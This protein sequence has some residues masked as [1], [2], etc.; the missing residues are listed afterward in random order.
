MT[1]SGS[2]HDEEV[3]GRVY[4]ARMMRRLWAYVRPH[5]G[6]ITL[7]L[8]LLVAVSAAQLAQP[9][10]IKMAIDGPIANGDARGLGWIVAAFAGLLVL[11]FSLRYLQIYAL[12]KTGQNVVHDL[13]VQVYGHLQT[14]SSNFFDRNPVGRLVTRVTTDVETLAEVFSS[15]VVTLLGDSLKLVGIVVLLFWMDARLAALTVTV[16]PL[17]GVVAFLFRI[18]IRDAFRMVRSRVARLNAYLAETLGGMTVVQLF[19]RERA[20]EKEFDEINRAHRDADLSS[21]VYDSIFSSIIELVGTLSLAMILWYG[22]GRVLLGA[23]TFGTLVAFLEYA[24]KF[25]GPIRELGGYYSV[26]QSAMASSER[27]FALMDT[28]PEIVAPASPKRLPASRPGVTGEVVFDDVRFA[29][30]GGPDVLRGLSFRAHPGEKVALVGSTGAGKTTVVR[31]LLRLYD[32]QEG[33][34]YLDGVNVRDLDP[35]ELRRR[36]GVVLQDHVLFSGTI[37]DNI[38]LGDAGI[39]R[40]RIERA[41]EAVRAHGFIGALPRGYDDD[42]RERGSNFSMGQRQLLSFARALAFDP[43]VLVLDEATASVDSRTEMEI[44]KA[45]RT[46]TGGRTSLVIAHRLSTI[47]ESD[48]ILVLHHGVV[49]EEGSHQQL[50]EM[51]GLYRMLH[52]LQFLEPVPFST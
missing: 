39:S 34:I 15:G 19:Q 35:R 7:S 30:P 27:I 17:L 51:D 50:L 31:L 13:R 20:N 52:R 48:R 1:G 11:E 42:V 4:D 2:H 26:M 45:L 43:P 21:V 46:L 23:I 22:G 9:Y 16:L 6:L 47:Q 18:R 8:L 33:A 3:L 5:H 28:A 25:F 29:Y 36:V 49:R 10:L 14:L 24:Q 37:A 32:P 41:A 44:Q 38:G 40:E 12:E